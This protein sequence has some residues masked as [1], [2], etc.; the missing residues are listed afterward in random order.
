MLFVEVIEGLDH[1]FVTIIGRIRVHLRVHSAEAC[2][3]V[4]KDSGFRESA[5]S[6]NAPQWV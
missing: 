4:D 6:I 5:H 1:M 3:V 2:P